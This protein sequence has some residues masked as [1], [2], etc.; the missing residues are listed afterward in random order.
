MYDADLVQKLCVD[1]LN[2]TDPGRVEELLA[3]LQAIIRDDQ[4]EVKVRIT[5]LAK[6]YGRFFTDA[7]AAD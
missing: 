3:L 5:F 7:K 6:K 1:V 2:E 4:E